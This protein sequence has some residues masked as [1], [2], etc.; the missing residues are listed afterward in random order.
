MN[1][2][3]QNALHDLLFMLGEQEFGRVEQ[4]WIDTLWDYLA[5]RDH[6]QQLILGEIDEGE[7]EDEE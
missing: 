7:T 2:E 5:S 6:G 3:Q 1:E 4:D